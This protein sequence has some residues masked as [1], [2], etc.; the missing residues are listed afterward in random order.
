MLITERQKEILNRMVEEYVY[1]AQPVGSQLLEK[2]YDFNICPAS[3][4]IEMQKLTD[5]GF[6]YQP[7]ISS[8]RVPTD[9]GYRFYVN[10]LFEKESAHE[11]INLEI[12]KIIEKEIKD[13]L[14]FI[15]AIT[16][17]LA[18]T[19]SDLVISY[20]FEDNVFWKEGWERVFQKPEFKETKLIGNFA[21]LIKNFEEAIE[22]FKNDFGV[23]IFIGRE[24]P[25]PKA[26]EF[27]TI[28]ARCHFPDNH[29]GLVAI[30]GPK[31]MT[32]DRNINSLKSLIAL[33]EKF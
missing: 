28:I 2:K 9:K 19:S 12:E 21:E 33:L 1:T 3:I 26:R 7:H 4:R 25:F 23:K 27:S 14:R 30:M 8:G 13:T 29:E 31:R 18:L 24:N 20:L 15:Q 10:S 16:K 5:A 6:F 32:Y 11:E 22:E 17:D